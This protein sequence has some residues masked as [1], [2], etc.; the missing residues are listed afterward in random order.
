VARVE[1]KYGF[2]VSQGPKQLSRRA[3][4]LYPFLLKIH[5][6]VIRGAHLAR[7]IIENICWEG[8]DRIFREF[9]TC[10]LKE[11]IKAVLLL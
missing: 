7:S 10:V 11:G 5:I 2:E 6:V 8:L 9:F 4:S 1:T 3:H